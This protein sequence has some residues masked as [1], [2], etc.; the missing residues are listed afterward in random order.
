MEWKL[1][2][3]V[4]TISSWDARN[5]K[6]KWRA[7]QTDLVLFHVPPAEL[8]TFFDPAPENKLYSSLSQLEAEARVLWCL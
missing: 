1:L 4:N 7:V 2:R 6:K 3:T 5:G 8:S